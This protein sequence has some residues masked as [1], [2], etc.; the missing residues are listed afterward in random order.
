MTHVLKGVSL[1]FPESQEKCNIIPQVARWGP[2]ERQ[3]FSSKEIKG[4]FLFL[5][6]WEKES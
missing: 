5:Q 6:F 2:K 4:Y 1:Q 3:F